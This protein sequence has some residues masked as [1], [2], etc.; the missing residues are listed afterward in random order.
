MTR[1]DFELMGDLHKRF[2]SRVFDTVLPGTPVVVRLDG[3]A[4]H[5]FTKGLKRPFDENLSLCMIETTKYLVSIFS[6][7]IGYTQSDEISLAFS[8]LDKDTPFI[9]SGRVQKLAS[10]FASTAT[11]KFNQLIGK[12]IPYKHELLPVFDCRVIQYPNL[13]TV[14]DYFLWRETDATRNSLSMAAQTY[15]C[16]KELHG[17]GFVKKHDMLHAKGINWNNYPP[18]FKRGSYVGRV[19][20]QKGLSEEER[21]RIPEAHRPTADMKFSRMEVQELD[22]EPITKMPYPMDQLFPDVV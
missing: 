7:N 21:M 22:F 8:N 11:A 1:D 14:C 6:P 3:K 13:E 5:T 12:H 2:E 16:Q 15:Y 18:H 4:F 17:A 20:V 9:Y 10:I 19:M